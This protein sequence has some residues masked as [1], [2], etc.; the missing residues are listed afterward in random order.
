MANWNDPTIS[1]LYVQFLADLKARDSDLAKMFD[2]GTPTN[3]ETDSIRWNSSAGRFE[4]WNG[5]TWDELAS[6]YNINADQL[7][8]NDASD[9][10]PASH[11]ALTNAHSATAAATAD[12]IALRDGSGRMKVANP[13]VDA[14]VANKGYVD[15]VGGGLELLGSFSPSSAASVDIN[16]VIVTTFRKYLVYYNLIPATDNAQLWVR[17][18]I[19][20]G[21]SFAAGGSAY[22]VAGDFVSQNG[23][24]TAFAGLNV[25]QMEITANAGVGNGSSQGVNGWF[26]IHDPT[27]AA[28]RTRLEF[29]TCVANPSP[30][31]EFASGA[32][33]RDAAEDN[34]AFRM[35]FS[36]GNMTGEV[37]VYGIK[38]A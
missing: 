27:D 18:S 1:T 12:R 28:I 10:A 2:V 3:V 15:G 20:N 9:F 38:E 13:S 16:S 23:S 26:L 35:L 17:S 7:D 24:H 22:D 5:A 29:A 36:G 21:G 19:N 25:A 4:K 6:I 33:W 8:G 32:A 34:D 31:L 30:N 37:R 11:V 14:D